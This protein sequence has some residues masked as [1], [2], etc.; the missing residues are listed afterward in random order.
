[1]KT[2]PSRINNHLEY[3]DYQD[4]LWNAYEQARQGVS[5]YAVLCQLSDVYQKLMRHLEAAY[6][7]R[8]G[9]RHLLTEAEINNLRRSLRLPASTQ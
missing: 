9:K 3:L 2:I 1:M 8:K 4:A 6:Y 5:D 7:W